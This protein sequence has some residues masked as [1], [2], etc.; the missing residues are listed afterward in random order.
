M[1]E[2]MEAGGAEKWLYA[3]GSD[4]FFQCADFGDSERDQCFDAGDAD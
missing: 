2:K 4:Y 3:A 1:G